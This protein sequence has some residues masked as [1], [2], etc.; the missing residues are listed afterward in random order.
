MAIG[1]IRRKATSDILVRCPGVRYGMVGDNTYIQLSVDM[2]AKGIKSRAGSIDML[3]ASF[4][5]AG[6]NTGMNA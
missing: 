4:A 5:A 6:H 2:Q 1:T 3:M